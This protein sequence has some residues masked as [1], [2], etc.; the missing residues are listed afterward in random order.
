MWQLYENDE[1]FQIMAKEKVTHDGQLLEKVLYG[2]E[3]K[4]NEHENP[5]QKKKI[6]K[7]GN[8]RFSFQKGSFSVDASLLGDEESGHIQ[9][10]S[11]TKDYSFLPVKTQEDLH[12]GD[13]A[14]VRTD[15]VVFDRHDTSEFDEKKENLK[16]DLVAWEERSKRRRDQR[17][18]ENADT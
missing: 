15:V 14:S 6:E 18:L 3:A 5:G 10:V 2:K 12:Y 11:R 7:N 9:Y 13:L 8:F 16:D 17:K 4:H 1:S